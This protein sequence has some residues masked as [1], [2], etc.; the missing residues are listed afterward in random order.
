MDFRRFKDMDPV[1]QV[2]I[3]GLANIH[4]FGPIISLIRLFGLVLNYAKPR[5][6]IQKIF[7]C[8]PT[9]VNNDVKLF[10]FF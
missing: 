10:E 6:F 9:R 2:H 3:F 1:E 5:L 7:Y 8:L 4:T